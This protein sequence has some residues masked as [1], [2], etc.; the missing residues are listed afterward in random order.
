M[1]NIIFNLIIHQPIQT[2]FEGEK[3]DTVGNL[4][5][6]LPTPCRMEEPDIFLQSI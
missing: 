2:E 4:K 1:K 3:E 6:A 5:S